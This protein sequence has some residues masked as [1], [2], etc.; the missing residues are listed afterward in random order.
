MSGLA[1][2]RVVVAL[3]RGAG[4]SLAAALKPLRAALRDARVSEG[5]ARSVAVLALTDAPI[6]AFEA[7]DLAVERVA[8]RFEPFTAAFGAPEVE[9]RDDGE[10]QVRATLVDADGRWA[11][12]HDALRDAIR[13]YGFEAVPP[14]DGPGLVLGRVATPDVDALRAAASGLRLGALAVD[15]LDVQTAAET[16]DGR[17]VFS[18][19]RRIPL[20]A[21][22]G[23]GARRD[24]APD[25]DALAAELERRMQR[26]SARMPVSPAPQPPAPP[27]AS[28]EPP[29]DE[30]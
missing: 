13:E 21:A 1:R 27:K 20:G 15:R 6:E 9:V 5:K 18:T 8:L 17:R 29:G 30:S 4:A 19:R 26:R 23:P 24:A 25:R 12:L 7:V 16:E 10:H 14:G 11:A 28:K 22:A 3:E 2:C